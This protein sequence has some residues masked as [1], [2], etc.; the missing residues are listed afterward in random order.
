MEIGDW[1]HQVHR[2]KIFFNGRSLA[3]LT[4]IKI[5]ISIGIKK[6]EIETDSRELF[7]LLNNDIF[8]LHPLCIIISN[9]RHRL[10]SFE[11][12][13]IFKIKREQNLCA[14]RLDKEARESELPTRTSPFCATRL[15]GGLLC[16]L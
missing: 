1:I 16:Y 12:T 15:P 5:G 2:T 8:N 3:L 13:K 14:N 4:G 11:D 7:F 10:S 9:C 6:M